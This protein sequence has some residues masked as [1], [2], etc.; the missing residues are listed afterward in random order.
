MVAYSAWKTVPMTG[1]PPSTSTSHSWLA[2]A[3]FVTFLEA[4]KAAC[5]QAICIGY[6]QDIV[7]SLMP[8]NADAIPTSSAA[9]IA[10]FLITVTK[11]MD[12]D[13]SVLW[14]TIQNALSKADAPQPVFQH[15]S[16]DGKGGVDMIVKLPNGFRRKYSVSFAYA[17]TSSAETSI[18][19]KAAAMGVL[20]FIESYKPNRAAQ[21]RRARKAG[22]KYATEKDVTHGSK[23]KW[24]GRGKGRRATVI[25][26]HLPATS[27]SLMKDR[28]NETLVIDGQ[29]CLLGADSPQGSPYGLVHHTHS[30]FGSGLGS[31]AGLA[32]ERAPHGDGKLSGTD[33]IQHAEYSPRPSLQMRTI[34]D[35]LQDSLY[36]LPKVWYGPKQREDPG[37]F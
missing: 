22:A 36:G 26:P 25:M 34:R 5:L 14:H 16:G 33:G 35:D 2:D 11:K 10:G 15:H 9:V 8:L 37:L 23:T 19:L 31:R 29:Q 18:V 21:L 30:T 4:K 20:E 27:A 13:Y 12:E 24:K 28:L 17:N 3:I 7:L 1:P 32:V 6:L